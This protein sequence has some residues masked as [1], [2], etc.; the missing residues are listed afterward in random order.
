[1]DKMPRFLPALL[2]TS[3]RALETQPS[4]HI[5]ESHRI[6]NLN[7]INAS[8]VLSGEYFFPLADRQYEKAV[9]RI[10]DVI[11]TNLHRGIFATTPLSLRFIRAADAYLSMAEGQDYCS[12]EISA[13]S[14]VHGAAE[15]ILSYER[16]CY[17]L[18]GRS[19]WGQL[20][21]QNSRPGWLESAYPKADKWKK[22]YRELNSAGVFDN[23]FT[24]RLGL[25]VGA[26]P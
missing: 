18:N 1:M 21:E 23:H 13:H 11:E 25:S 24:D 17:E 3:M 15:A 5:E 14:A 16:I 9:A 4:G 26:K 6:F 7:K 22:V 19:H 2:E 8:E 12:M 20:N 10:L